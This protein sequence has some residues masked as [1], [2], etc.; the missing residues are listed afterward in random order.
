MNTTKKSGSGKTNK[1]AGES[2]LY[3]RQHAHNPVEWY[4]WGKEALEKA[5]NE[6]KPLLVSVG[7]SACHWCH[8]M[9][10]ESFS[11]QEVAE[12]M[13]QNFINI[14]IDREERP[15]LDQLYMEA[16]QLLHGHGGWPL[17]C[18]ALPDG[19]PFWGATYFKKFQ[20][21][22]VLDQI[23]LL[24]KTE[25]EKLT[26]QAERISSGINKMNI[27]ISP[28]QKSEIEKYSH[29]NLYR[30]LSGSFDSELGG[31]SGAPKFPMPSVYRLLLHYYHVSKNKQALDH[32]ILTLNR[33]AAGGIYDQ[34]GGGFA[35]YSTDK[36]WKVPHFE[37]MLYDNAQ[38]IT[39][40]SEAYLVC[41]QERLKEIAVE[42]MQFLEREM[43]SPETGF[44]ASID[45]DSTEGE[46]AFYTFTLDELTQQLGGD[47][48]L[49]TKYW[50]AGSEGLWEG[51]KNILLAP[52]NEDEFIKNNGL[53]TEDFRT[54]LRNARSVLL[55]YRNKRPKPATDTKRIT[56]WNALLVQAYVN[57]FRITG[58]EMYLEN[59]KKLAS[60]IL[61][62]LGDDNHKLLHLE[63]SGKSI[64]GFLDDYSAL[65]LSLIALHS[66]SLE[67][68]WLIK[69]KKLADSAIAQFFDKNSG[70][71]YF[72]GSNHEKAFAQRQELHDNVIPSANSMMMESL[73]LLGQIF[74]DNAYSE[75]VNRALNG[76]AENILK[77]STAFSNWG[78]L[79]LM[80]RFPFH[81]IAVSGHDAGILIGEFTQHFLPQALL[82][83]STT[84][85]SLPVFRSRHVENETLIYVCSGKECYPPANSVTEALSYLG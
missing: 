44:S 76:M 1:L 3:L 58:D 35:R 66:A 15:D 54:K 28:D 82:S 70:L 45:A 33:M 55:L 52:A 77:H 29:E 26:D 68:K 81:T 71:F 22:E 7:Y 61:T 24:Y 42:T 63:R 34:A 4:P 27:I 67:E 10:H 84:A 85:S 38:L 69:A 57:L 49:L 37:K 32:V 43:G 18:F 31:F 60:F 2:S 65:I 25:L 5:M 53:S 41:K 23:A 46:G 19:R 21:I 20:W 48:P 51:G 62:S 9:E 83:G 73:F 56:A 75:I 64:P 50:K 40:Y 13:N 36:H 8:V 74:E 72:T 17:N 30:N 80:H 39:L 6:N 16:V 11:D 12:I 79:F 59:S 78:R 14:K 47:A